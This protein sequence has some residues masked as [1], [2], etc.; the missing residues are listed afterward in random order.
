MKTI[1][2]N[3]KRMIQTSK[4]NIHNFTLYLFILVFSFSLLLDSIKKNY[5]KIKYEKK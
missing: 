5:N 4:F 3:L 1:M 2:A